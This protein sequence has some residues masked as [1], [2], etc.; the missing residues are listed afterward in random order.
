MQ[1]KLFRSRSD[2]MIGGVCGGLGRYLG[3][4]STFVRL[5]FV[6]I[7]LGPGI[8]VLVYLVL[9]IL[10]PE[11]GQERG[12]QPTFGEGQ[13]TEDRIEAGA[14]QFAER[15]RGM[16]DDLR[17]A[18]R[19]PHPQAT[20]IIGGALV[21][22]GAFY[23][24]DNLNLPGLEAWLRWLD[25]DVLWPLLLILGGIVLLVRHRRGG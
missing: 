17:E 5:F 23:L 9:W 20:L 11:E 7:A 4:D 16:G 25:F 8:G 12:W 19:N 2:R 13:T 10:L 1:T 21:L 6:L 18:V 3:I 14:S 22:L 24:L 15:A